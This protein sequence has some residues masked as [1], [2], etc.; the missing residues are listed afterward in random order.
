[1]EAKLKQKF[2]EDFD[3]VDDVQELILDDL[4]KIDKISDTDK[5]FLEKFKNL[6]HISFNLLG[7]TSVQNLPA[8]PTVEFV[9]PKKPADHY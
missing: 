5:K 3:D 9:L 1:M 2:K 4:V 7:L 6:V 8:I